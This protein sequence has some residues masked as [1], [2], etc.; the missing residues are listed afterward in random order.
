MSTVATREIT[1]HFTLTH[2]ISVIAISRRDY[3]HYQS[4]RAEEGRILAVI[5]SYMMELDTD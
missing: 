3:F 1:H 5:A 2:V 4:H